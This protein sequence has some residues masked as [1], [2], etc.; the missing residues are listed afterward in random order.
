MST[1][2]EPTPSL[3]DFGLDEDGWH[4]TKRCRVRIGPYEG[5]PGFQLYDSETGNQFA[6]MGLAMGGATP[7]ETVAWGERFESKQGIRFERP[8]GWEE[9]VGSH[10]SDPEEILLAFDQRHVEIGGDPYAGLLGVCSDREASEAAGYTVRKVVFVE[11]DKQALIN[12][13]GSIKID[14]LA[15]KE[16]IAHR[17]H[18]YNVRSRLLSAGKDLPHID[19]QG[20]FEDDALELATYLLKKES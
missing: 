1:P 4:P 8:E 13:Y 6:V 7:E 19:T 15:T 5:K 3:A 11:D 20:I 2:T 16:M 18:I 14:S 17:D 10:P 12:D 9:V